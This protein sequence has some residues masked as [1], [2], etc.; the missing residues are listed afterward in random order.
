MTDPK[1]K[2]ILKKNDPFDQLIMELHRKGVL[3][4]CVV[5]IGKKTVGN[6]QH[7]YSRRLVPPQGK[8]GS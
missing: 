2:K 7:V 3:D 5:G 4:V 6:L 8:H 1:Y